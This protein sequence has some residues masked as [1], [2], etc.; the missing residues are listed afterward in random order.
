MGN[1]LAEPR[2]QLRY[3]NWSKPPPKPTTTPPFVGT[4]S[5]P[6]SPLLFTKQAPLLTRPSMPP[7]TP[8]PAN[9]RERNESILVDRVQSGAVSVASKQSTLKNLTQQI[10]KLN[11]DNVKKDEEVRGLECR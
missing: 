9:A 1:W 2:R 8:K 7:K 10:R 6:R 3:K 11:R 4:L 5:I